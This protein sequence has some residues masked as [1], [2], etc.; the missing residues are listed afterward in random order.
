MH[1]SLKQKSNMGPIGP[2]GKGKGGDEQ[3]AKVVKTAEKI[4]NEEKMGL[5]AAMVKEKVFANGAPH[6]A[7]VA[8]PVE[9]NGADT[10]MADAKAA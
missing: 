2:R 6:V 1:D 5:M 7:E 8:R 9:V 4:A 3:M 10:Q